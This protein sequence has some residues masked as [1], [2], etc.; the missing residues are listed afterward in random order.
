MITTVGKEEELQ[1]WIQAW[2]HNISTS[3]NYPFMKIEILTT[4]TIVIEWGL[5]DSNGGFLLNRI[6]FLRISSEIPEEYLV[7]ILKCVKKHR[8]KY[9]RVQFFLN[10]RKEKY[11]RYFLFKRLP[12]PRK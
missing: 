3:F 4:K 7:D 2:K 5:V 10:K 1:L 9:S 11:G 12:K 6:A 8:L